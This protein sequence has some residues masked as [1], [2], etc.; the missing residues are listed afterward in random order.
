[1]QSERDTL[2]SKWLEAQAASK[3]AVETERLLR[4][5]VMQSFFPEK[6]PDEGTV[7]EEL[8]NGYKLKFVFKQNITLNKDKVEDAL[9]EIER[10]GEDGKFIAG[11]LIKFKP[12]LSLTEYK[13]LEPKMKKIID[14]VITSKPGSPTIEFIE[15]KAKA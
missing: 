15:P 11:R 5:Q 3:A 12:E 13:Q 14:K 7:N 6:Q 2:I 4:V 8:G 9:S 1:M 10:L